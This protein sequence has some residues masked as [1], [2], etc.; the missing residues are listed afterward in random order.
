MAHGKDFVDFDNASLCVGHAVRAADAGASSAG[1]VCGC[2]VFGSGT[3]RADSDVVVCTVFRA[4]GL[5]GYPSERCVGVHLGVCSLKHTGEMGDLV[6]GALE[7]IEKHQ[8]ESARVLELNR[9]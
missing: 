1:V 7:S 4:I 6:R 9:W 3:D 5:D 8:V 2:T